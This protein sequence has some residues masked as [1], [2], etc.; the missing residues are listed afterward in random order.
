MALLGYSLTSL[1]MGGDLVQHPS[2]FV[3]PQFLA[4]TPEDF[5]GTVW[6]FNWVHEALLRGVP[7]LQPDTVCA[8]RG[9]SLGQQFPN[10]A[11]AF[12]AFPLFHFFSFPTN[13]N[14]WL[15]SIPVL[16]AF[17]AFWALRGMGTPPWLAWMAGAFYGFTPYSYQEILAGRPSTGLI[18]AIPLFVGLYHRALARPGRLGWLWAVGSGLGAAFA[19]YYHP[20]QA[21]I[22]AV[23]GL[24]MLMVALVVPAPG[25]ARSRVLGTTALALLLAAFL[26]SSYLYQVTCLQ[27]RLPSVQQ[28]QQVCP[29]GRSLLPPWSPDL[30]TYLLETAR[31][32]GEGRQGRGGFGGADPTLT[33]EREERLDSDL[34]RAA[35]L[36]LPISV[37]W[38]EN[39]QLTDTRNQFHPWYMALVLALLAASAGPAAWGWL[40]MALLMLLLTLG[41][42]L[43]TT[44]HPQM[45]PLL[46]HGARLR[47][48]DWYLFSHFPVLL[49]FLKPYRLFPGFLLALVLAGTKGLETWLQRFAHLRLRAGGRAFS[50]ELPVLF[51]GL[52]VMLLGLLRLG[53]SVDMAD[54]A[55]SY[56]PDQFLAELGA[57]TEDYGIIEMPVG[58]GHAYGAFQAIHGKRRSESHHDYLPDLR[59]G[60]AAPPECYGSDLLQKLWWLGRRSPLDIANGTDLHGT[61]DSSG[62]PSP[63]LGGAGGSSGI[64]L[65]TLPSASLS[66]QDFQRA[67]QQGFRYVVLYPRAYQRLLEK[68]VD[69]DTGQVNRV[70]ESFLGPPVHRGRML[71]AYDLRNLGGGVD[72]ISPGVGDSP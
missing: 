10:W 25:V 57:D 59:R 2:R 38:T 37:L 67:L 27:G 28:G 24:A 41:P 12:M 61:P 34:R 8:P 66:I 63:G 51:L 7:I 26:S 40:G 58:L 47:L 3:G 22:C 33:R 9:I 52:C 44:I 14:L 19:V 72:G 53:A 56:T 4:F 46:F 31:D 17:C 43:Q 15:A 36:S 71:L 35:F 13:Y 29:S 20:L 18:M 5:H 65:A 60:A 69:V 32:Q 64:D 70:L 48:P 68:G 21:F 49:S 30:W 23:L 55:R 11:D 62:P 16:G 6:F 54:W 50:T 39:T 42:W 1:L 45:E